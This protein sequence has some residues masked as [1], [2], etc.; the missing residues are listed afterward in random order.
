[1]EKVIPQAFS[2]FLSYSLLALLLAFE[3]KWGD[4]SLRVV[5]AWSNLVE[6]LD[7]LLLVLTL[8]V[9]IENNWEAQQ[10]DKGKSNALSKWKWHICAINGIITWIKAQMFGLKLYQLCKHLI[11]EWE[12]SLRPAKQGLGSKGSNWSFVLH[13]R[14]WVQGEKLPSSS[15]RF[16]L[17]KNDLEELFDILES[18]KC[19]LKLIF[20]LLSNIPLGT[21]WKNSMKLGQKPA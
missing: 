12:T 15:L 13:E 21:M 5:Q 10:V 7:K 2:R 11:M 16:S 1:M 20:E 19:S 6:I 14:A 8:L 3:E 17:L 9:C 18:L 4:K